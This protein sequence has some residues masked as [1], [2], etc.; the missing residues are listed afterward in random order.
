[1][2]EA[3]HVVHFLYEWISQRDDDLSDVKPSLT[4]QQIECLQA[5]LLN[6]FKAFAI[7]VDSCLED[8]EI[9]TQ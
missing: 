6:S 3:S 8:V 7:A 2:D 4:P 9:L 1:M 5:A